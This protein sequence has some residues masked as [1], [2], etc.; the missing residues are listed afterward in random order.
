[1]RHKLLIFPILMLLSCS[2]AMAQSSPPVASRTL[3]KRAP[4]PP[5]Q[6]LWTYGRASSPSK[7]KSVELD[8]KYSIQVPDGFT[9]RRV[10]ETVSSV[11]SYFFDAEPAQST[12]ITIHVMPFASD[13]LRGEHSNVQL[14]IEF[15]DILL[16]GSFEFSGGET[17]YYGWRVSNNAYECR[18]NKSCMAPDLPE[19]RYIA[20]Y[21]FAVFDKTSNLTVEF[22]G[23]YFGPSKKV[24]TF[25]GEGKL[26]RD[27]IIPS[28]TRIH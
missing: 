12:L 25:K 8:R 21:V 11:P 5:K 10:S 7:L 20:Q 15:D 9:L 18:V 24:T 3:K 6:S 16:T 1:M 22:T 4:N 23:F 28:L 27:I 19:S 26:L 2:V 14:P 13:A 17:A